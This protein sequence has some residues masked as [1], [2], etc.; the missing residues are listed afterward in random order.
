MLRSLQAHWP[1]Y[2]MEGA[3]LGAFMVSAGLF[4]TLLYAE[5]S[6]VPSLIPHA[7]LRGVLMGIAMGVSAI[8]IIYSP[9]G[10]RSGAHFNPAV[11]LA[12]YRLGKLAA[13]DA[14]FYV[15]AQF[16]GGLVGVVL[17][18]GVLGDPFTRVPVNYVVTIPG[19][20]GW[21][22]ALVAEAGMAFG[23]MSM[24][25]VVSNHPKLHEFTG[26]FAGILVT[27][28]II[29]AAPISGMSINPARTFASG[30]PADIW[31]A[32]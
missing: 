11:T 21:G 26:V 25:L 9:W 5:S 15:L 1:E 4:A 17:V 14:I 3:E 27:L 12:F 20:W 8:A 23:L 30:L 6:P 13:W 31:T 29:I 19:A 16:I 10:K 18:A 7:F 24:V 28:F 2:L 32:F 22:A